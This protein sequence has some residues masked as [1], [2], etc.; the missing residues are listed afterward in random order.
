MPTFTFSFSHY[1]VLKM[2]VNLGGVVIGDFGAV[3]QYTVLLY[4]CL[5]WSKSIAENPFVAEHH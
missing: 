4:S 5:S 3:L 2:K 1:L